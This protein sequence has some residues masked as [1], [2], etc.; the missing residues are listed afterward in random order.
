MR[1]FAF[2][3]VGA[4]NA[5]ENTDSNCIMVGDGLGMLPPGYVFVAK[6][7]L[8]QVAHAFPSFSKN[9]QSPEFSL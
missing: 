5:I 1:T 8:P 7:T 6:H 4:V 3:K 9:V 2:L